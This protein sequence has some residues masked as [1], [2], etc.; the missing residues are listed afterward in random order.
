[1]I[2]PA[3][4]TT[5]AIAVGT[6]AGLLSARTLDTLDDDDALALGTCLSTT[7]L[8]ETIGLFTFIAVFV[9]AIF[10]MGPSLLPLTALFALVGGLRIAAVR[11]IRGFLVGDL[12]LDAGSTA[13]LLP[14]ATSMRARPVP[15]ATAQARQAF[16]WQLIHEARARRTPSAGH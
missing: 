13:L 7:P 8:H 11:R 6:N 15:A 3:P 2:S 14:V 16:G 12:G 9:G 1:M 10:I 5:S 4:P